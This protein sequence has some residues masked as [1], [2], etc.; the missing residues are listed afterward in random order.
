ML[1]LFQLLIKSATNSHNLQFPE[2]YQNFYFVYYQCLVSVKMCKE[3]R[4]H[5]FNILTQFQYALQKQRLKDFQRYR[6]YIDTYKFNTQS[7]RNPL[8]QVMFCMFVSKKLNVTFRKY[9]F[10]IFY[11]QICFSLSFT[12][13]L[14]ISL[15]L[16]DVVKIKL[17][18]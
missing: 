15:L 17:N 5:N 1:V 8:T 12:Y 3:I 13:F 11:S 7:T 18:T 16:L 9:S 10:M 14:I 6:R 2:S 4:F